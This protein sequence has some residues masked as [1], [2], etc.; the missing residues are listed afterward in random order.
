MA[1]SKPA[2]L[3]LTLWTAYEHSL[4]TSPIRTKAL[5]SAT[6]SALGDLVSQKLLEKKGKFR[7]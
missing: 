1:L 3:V 6:L 2:N 4:T 7:L 5:T